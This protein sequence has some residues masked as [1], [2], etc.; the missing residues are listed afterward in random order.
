MLAR[1]LGRRVPY[2]VAIDRDEQSV[3]LAGSHDGVDYLLADFLNHPFRAGSFDLVVFLASLHHM[4]AGA[5][6][7]RTEE[8][9]RA[10]GRLAVI[11]LARSRQ[12][13]DLAFD[14]AGHVAHL[15]HT[16]L[17]TEWERAAPT[18]WP[19]PLTFGRMRRM[20]ARELPGSRDRRHL[21]SRYSLTWTKPDVAHRAASLPRPGRT[22][23]SAVLDLAL[24]NRR[25]GLPVRW[26]PAATAPS[27]SRSA[28]SDPTTSVAQNSSLRLRS[29]CSGGCCPL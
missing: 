13:I 18:V 20:A 2:I 1:E 27:T 28:G 5:A 10:G 29:A 22:A 21:L 17:R 3:R 19:P 4:D 6:F 16:R 11:G 8:L 23:A 7:R 24:V 9:L 26:S 14:V 12:P 25:S 15:I